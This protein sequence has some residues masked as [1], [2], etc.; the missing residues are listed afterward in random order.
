LSRYRQLR[1]V[2]IL[3]ILFAA[4]AP[5]AHALDGHFRIGDF[6]HDVWG[7]KEGAPSTVLT[8]AQTTDGW[9]WLG[10]YRGLYRFD[11][12]QFERFEPFPGESLTYN[13]ISTLAAAP[14]GDLLIAYLTGGFSI[15]RNGHLLHMTSVQDQPFANT[16]TVLSD[17]DGTYWIGAIDGLMHLDGRTW[18]RVGAKW[19]YPGTRTD[20]LAL[21][22]YGRL[23]VS[24]G[25]DVHVLDRASRT[26]RRTGLRSVEMSADFVYDPTGAL[27]IATDDRMTPVAVDPGAL[28]PMHRVN[29][30]PAMTIRR[31]FDRDGNL[32]LTTDDN[33]VCMLPRDVVPSSGAFATTALRSAQYCTSPRRADQKVVGLFEDRD[34]NIWLPTINGLE[35]L[36]HNR[37]RTIPYRDPSVRASLARDAGGTITA[38]A[39]GVA[40]GYYTI[41]GTALQPARRHADALLHRPGI[42]GTV[43]LATPAGLVVQ[44][45]E[46]ERTI[47]Y[48]LPAPAPTDPVRRLLQESPDAF[49]VGWTRHGLWRY[50][51]GTWTKPADYGTPVARAGDAS[52][53]NGNVWLAYANNTVVRVGPA[54]ERKYDARDGVDVRVATF[55]DV[56][57]GVLIAGDGGLQ[58]LSG[59]RFRHVRAF[60]PDVLTG[61]NGLLIAPDGDRWFNTHR[62]VLHVRAADWQAALGSPDSLLRYELL[63]RLDG[64]P[65]GAQIGIVATTAGVPDGRM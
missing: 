62:G 53:G 36:R 13:A 45:G 25:A 63:D 59:G 50:A 7:P 56:Q 55:I 24:D 64:F 60:D 47:P 9:L 39:G 20:N 65:D 44:Q 14:N 58:V 26:F 30:P 52:D 12:V 32:W 28:K 33:D 23:F 51:G 1:A 34:G 29:T 19:H 43:V 41:D 48:P 16:F 5:A 46:R 15:L 42:D 61:I 4:L 18:E 6:H 10:T 37:L 8:I 35:R 31:L 3:L 40:T 11:G 17:V 54:G 2:A 21:D 49:W 27:W 57:R 38:V 22:R